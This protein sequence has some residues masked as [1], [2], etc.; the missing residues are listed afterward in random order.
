MVRSITLDKQ[1]E[2]VQIADL[3]R[4][5]EQGDAKAEYRLGVL[6][7]KEPHSTIQRCRAL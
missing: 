4:Q 5:A 6:Y 2:N 3:R 7:Q 1:T